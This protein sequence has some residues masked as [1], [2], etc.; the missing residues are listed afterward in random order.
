M[1]ELADVVG[2][3]KASMSRFETGDSRVPEE[4]CPKLDAVFGTSGLFATL[5]E[6][7][8]NVPFPDRYSEYMALEREAIALSEWTGF[9]ISGLLQTPGYMRALFRDGNPGASDAR[10]A[11]LIERRM[12]RRVIFDKKPPPYLKVLLDE[13]VLRRTMGSPE[14]MIEQLEALL[15]TMDHEYGNTR[16]LPLKHG[17]FGLNEATQIYIELP[18]GTSLAYLEGNATS[19]MI[20]EPGMVTERKRDYERAAAYA[21]SPAESAAMIRTV[22]KE[23]EE[24]PK[25]PN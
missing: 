20:E 16:V 6:M 24:C 22:I 19:R 15:G 23:Y 25:P 9:H 18:D 11:T 21:L 13:S 3:S 1:T 14:V 2:Y 17:G 5:F 7:L 4:L 10:V 12:N 8:R